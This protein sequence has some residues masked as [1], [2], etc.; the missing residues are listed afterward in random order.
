MLIKKEGKK[1]TKDI[2]LC[3]KIKLRL[4]G[5]HFLTKKKW[6]EDENVTMGRKTLSLKKM[7]GI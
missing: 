4:N 1:S 7:F 6:E 2:K 5:F 3:Q